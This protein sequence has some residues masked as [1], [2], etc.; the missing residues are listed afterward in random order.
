VITKKIINPDIGKGWHY[1]ANSKVKELVHSG[2]V[3]IETPDL[4]HVYVSGRTATDGDTDQIVGPGDIAAQT[5]QVLINLGSALT[6]A[7]ATYDDIDRELR[8]V[9]R[10][11]GRVLQEGALPGQHAG[12]RP[13]A[14]P[15]RRHARDRLRR[16]GHQEQGLNRRHLPITGSGPEAS[17]RP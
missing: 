4:K 11:P 6:E 5:R 8:Q 17:R 1:F 16:R 3:V 13:P 10:G 14:R 2:A 15:C 12:D 7:G 9:A